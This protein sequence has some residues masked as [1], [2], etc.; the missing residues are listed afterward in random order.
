VLLR[1]SRLVL[2]AVAGYGAPA[3][4]G[5]RSGI[6]LLDRAVLGNQV[7]IAQLL[8]EHGFTLLLNAAS[9]DFGD[10]SMIALLLMTSLD[11]HTPQPPRGARTPACR[12]HTRVNA[13]G[14]PD[15][16]VFA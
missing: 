15:K 7:D 12:V 6:T 10:S 14:G 1:C 4:D 3:D 9:I 8:I 16:N 5:E 11:Q 13:F 2:R